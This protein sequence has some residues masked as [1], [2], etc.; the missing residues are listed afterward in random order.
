[1]KNIVG[2]MENILFC[3]GI[4]EVKVSVKIIKF[5]F[6]AKHE[7]QISNHYIQG[8]EVDLLDTGSSEENEENKSFSCESRIGKHFIFTK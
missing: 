7:S 8:K 4:W 6:I 1:M 3:Q 2:N 5:P